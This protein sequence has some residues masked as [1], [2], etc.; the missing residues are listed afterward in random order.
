[1]TDL[2]GNSPWN[3][4]LPPFQQCH[5]TEYKQTTVNIENKS[6]REYFKHRKLV[7][8]CKLKTFL[9][10]YFDCHTYGVCHTSKG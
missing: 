5:F 10:N 8:M 2:V 3:G 7:S 6:F 9:E 4:F 1:M